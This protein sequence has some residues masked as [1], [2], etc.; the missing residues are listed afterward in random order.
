MVR[1]L[2]ADYDGEKKLRYLKGQG[3]P[4]RRSLKEMGKIWVISTRGL[5][6]LEWLN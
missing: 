5:S 6:K 4:R 3:L 1:F 2:S